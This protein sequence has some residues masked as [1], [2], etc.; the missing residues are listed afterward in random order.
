MGKGG[1]V[2]ALVGSVIL[3]FL[4]FYF[5]LGWAFG[6]LMATTVGTAGALVAWV[7]ICIV[8]LVVTAGVL[9]GLFLLCMAA[10]E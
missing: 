7:I 6:N 8:L 1:F 3:G 9:F 2:S 5:V 4:W 10:A